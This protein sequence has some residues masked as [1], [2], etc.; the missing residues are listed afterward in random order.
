MNERIITLDG[1][2]LTSSEVFEVATNYSQVKIAEESMIR[3]QN[4]R[5]VVDRILNEGEVVYGINTGFGSLVN[6]QINSEQLETLQLNLVRSH[7]T[8]LGDLMSVEEVRA[9]MCVR[10]NS[11]VKGNSGCHPDVINQLVTFLNKGI[12]PIVPRIGSLGASGDLA[13]L[14]HLALGLIGEGIVEFENKTRQAKDVLIECELL[15]LTLRAKD[16]LSLINGT[17]QMTGFL[18]LALERLKNLLTYSCLL[19]TSPSP[20]D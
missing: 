7:A 11:L 4:A 2:T 9:M 14:S 12:H 8:G 13:P 6:T 10:I 19:Y 15:P 16:G 20:R 18:C 5:S 1:T 3:V 17:S